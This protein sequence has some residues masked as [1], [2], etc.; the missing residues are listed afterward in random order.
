MTGATTVATAT[1]TARPIARAVAAAT[2][3]ATPAATAVATATSTTSTPLSVSVSG[4]HLVNQQGQ[5]IRLIGVNRN[6]VSNCVTDQSVFQGSTAA[7]QFAAWHINFVRISV[8]E[9]CWLGINGVP[10]AYSGANYQNA[11]I[12]FVNAL[13]SYGI[14]AEVDLHWSAPGTYQSDMQQSMPDADHATAYWRSV[15]TAFKNDPAVIFELYNEPHFTGSNSLC[16]DLWACW[17]DGGTMTTITT[18]QTARSSSCQVQADWQAVGMQSLVNTIRST[19]AT[20]PIV[21][22]VLNNGRASTYQDYLS[23][24][25]SDPLNQLMFN[26]HAYGTA[27][28]T[29][30]TWWDSYVAPI[31]QVMPAL[32]DEFGENDC[33]GAYN[34]AFMTWADAHGVGYAPYG[35]LTWPCGAYGMLGAYDGTPS[36]Y[37]QFFYD[38]FQHLVVTP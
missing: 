21:V 22:E 9:D 16:A 2:S 38:H 24:L 5:T 6:A 31:A 10:A 7:A 11:I 26:W 3:T 15:A 32:S 13:R 8:N 19:G 17:R 35:W 37:G 1:S 36:S 4:N 30:T 34:T 14:Y 28:N 20:N 29:S 25:P 33:L 18:C 12:S 23:H 27:A